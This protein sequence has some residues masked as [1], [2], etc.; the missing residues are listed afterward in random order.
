MA[1]NAVAIITVPA[2]FTHYTVFT[3]LVSTLKS[4]SSSVVLILT[5]II[6]CRLY[7]VFS[8]CGMPCLLLAG[9]LYN[10]HIQFYENGSG[11]ARVEIGDI[12]TH[13][14]SMLISRNNFFF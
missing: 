8:W 1:S 5:F 13:K 4:A 2:A 11:L 10:V 9:R 6:S 3:A 12:V 7:Y 14:N